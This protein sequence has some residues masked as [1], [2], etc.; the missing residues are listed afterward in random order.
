M[1]ENEKRFRGT[2][3]K[4]AKKAIE[5]TRKLLDKKSKCEGWKF[6][7]LSFSKDGY[8]V[9]TL[10]LGS[11]YCKEDCEKFEKLLRTGEKIIE[12]KEFDRFYFTI[13]FSNETIKIFS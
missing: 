11:Y 12:E 3:K 5:K 4:E 6:V 8:N 9:D 7:Y 2:S 10:N 13:T 1:V